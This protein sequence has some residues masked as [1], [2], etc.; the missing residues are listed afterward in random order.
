MVEKSGVKGSKSYTH[1]LSIPLNLG[2]EMNSKYSEFKGHVLPFLDSPGLLIV[3]EKLHLT[4]AMLCLKNDAE[5]SR[6]GEIM[7]AVKVASFSIELAG[8]E[9]MKGTVE[10]CHILYAKVRENARLDNLGKELMLRLAQE[11]FIDEIHPIKVNKPHLQRV[12]I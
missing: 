12:I 11:G 7:R 4:V 8:L 1:F 6:V 10:A 2:G 9:M 5:I 3:P